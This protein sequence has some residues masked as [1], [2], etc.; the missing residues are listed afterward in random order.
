MLLAWEHM[1]RCTGSCQ[2]AQRVEHFAQF[3]SVLRCSFIH[4]GELRRGKAQRLVRNSR[5]GAA[6][7]TKVDQLRTLMN[8]VDARELIH[9]KPHLFANM[10][11]NTEPL[12]IVVFAR[13]AT[14]ITV[15]PGN[16]AVP[17]NG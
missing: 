15:N 16:R 12:L 1:P 6:L 2:S 8:D 5:N 14:L 9:D 11:G 4:Q 17:G 7:V 13:E 10:L 3:L